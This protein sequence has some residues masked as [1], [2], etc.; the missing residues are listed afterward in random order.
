MSD[1]LYIRLYKLR[2]VFAGLLIIGN[3]FVISILISELGDNRVQAKPKQAQIATMYDNPNVVTSGMFRIAD[4]FGQA[5]DSAGYAIGSGVQAG[6]SATAHAGQVV[7]RGTWTGVTTVAR[8]TWTGVTTAARATGTG[9]AFVG[10]GVGKSAVFVGHTVGNGLVFVAKIPA[11]ILGFVSKTATASTIT[12]PSAN[13]QVP[14]IDPQA[15]I[16]VAGNVPLLAVKEAAPPVKVS[17][18]EGHWPIHGKI[19]TRFGVPHWPYQ[20]THTGLDI[21]SQR[22]SGV[23]AVHPFKP[24]RVIERVYSKY[25][26]GNHVV[27][28]HGGGLTSV[29]A[30]L[31]SITVRVGHNVNRATIIGYEGSTGLSTGTHLH[32]EIRLKGRPVDPWPYITGQR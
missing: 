19:T 3:L 27:V 4:G 25:G 26:L 24:G 16:V 5:M 12:R 28:D 23:T 14:V 17:H 20:P 22:R 32:F 15:P 1:R 30:H 18:T 6:A 10:R 13:A 21:S 7:A 31:A 8:G 11:N 29:Y 2:F 9:I